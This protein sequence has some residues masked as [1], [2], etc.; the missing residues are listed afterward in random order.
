MMKWKWTE[1]NNIPKLMTKT[2]GNSTIKIEE[3]TESETKT[4]KLHQLEVNESKRQL[5][6]ILPIDG[7]FNQEFD[8]RKTISTNLG[9]K[10]Y[11]ALLTHYKSII[12]Y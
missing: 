7:N 2:D 10:M 11:V 5:G 3:I 4:I 12:V 1:H 8:K 9:K 6:V